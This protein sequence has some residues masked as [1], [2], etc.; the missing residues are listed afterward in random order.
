MHELLHTLGFWHEQSRPD[1]DYHIK[2]NEEN[3]MPNH[4]NNFAKQEGQTQSAPYDTCSIM[5]Y[6]SNAFRNQVL[7]MILDIFFVFVKPASCQTT[8]HRARIITFIE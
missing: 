3:I 1:R 7:Y 8:K 5:H 6:D 4:E 2:I